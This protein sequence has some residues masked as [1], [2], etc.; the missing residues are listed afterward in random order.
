MFFLKQHNYEDVLGMTGLIAIRSYRKLLTGIYC[1]F[2]RNK[3]LQRLQ[4]HP[5][6]GAD[7]HSCKTNT[8][9]HSVSPARRMHFI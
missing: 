5:S 4:W 2:D 3:Y 9:S 7:P 1:E 6:E 8:R